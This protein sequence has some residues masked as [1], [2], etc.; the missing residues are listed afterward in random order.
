MS[1]ENINGENPNE[2]SLEELLKFLRSQGFNLQEGN[3][4]DM[5]KGLPPPPA[6]HWKD[7]EDCRIES[8]NVNLPKVC[9]GAVDDGDGDFYSVEWLKALMAWTVDAE[10]YEE[11]AKV[12]DHIPMTE[13]LIS[14][15]VITIDSD[16]YY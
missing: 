4:I 15:G 12:R 3:I 1:E 13:N 16:N 6:Q 2:R 7:C 8:F 9:E 14:E 11:A 10:M 5:G